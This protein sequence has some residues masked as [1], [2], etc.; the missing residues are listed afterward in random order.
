[1]LLAVAL[2]LALAVLLF[3]QGWSDNLNH[4][5]L[6]FMSTPCLLRV[7]FVSTSCLLHIWYNVQALNAIYA[8]C[9]SYQHDLPDL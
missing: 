2:A 5:G 9:T 1:M 8:G 6:Y 3:T 4:S 7:Y